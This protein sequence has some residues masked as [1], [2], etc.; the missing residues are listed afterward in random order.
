MGFFSRVFCVFSC[1][2][3]S[4]SGAELSWP[5]WRGTSGQGVTAAKDVPSQWSETVN[6]KWK[7][8]LKGRGWSTPVVQG[9]QV[10]VTTAI[11]KEASAEEAKKRLVG[12]TGDQPLTVL[13]P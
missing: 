4:A 11:E 1:V 3:L 7:T 10:W 9:D 5:E 12:N 8:A 6:V 2:I 13:I